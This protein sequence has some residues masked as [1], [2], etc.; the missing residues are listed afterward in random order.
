MWPRPGSIRVA[1][2][3]RCVAMTTLPPPVIQ[4]PLPPQPPILPHPPSYL[5]G[6][7]QFVTIRQQQH[8]HILSTHSN[9]GLFSSTFLRPHLQSDDRQ[10]VSIIS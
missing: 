4:L 7:S 5:D 10:F 3:D 2:A 6:I 9:I 8:H 1:A